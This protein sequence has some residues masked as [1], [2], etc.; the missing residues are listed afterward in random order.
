MNFSVWCWYTVYLRLGIIS[1]DKFVFVI[2]WILAISQY[3]KFVY[4]YTLDQVL[5][6]SANKFD[7][8]IISTYNL[9]F[10]NFP[11]YICTCV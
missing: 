9:N 2:T 3:G 4:V 11:M 1:A 8:V 5:H 7:F 6:I 10:S